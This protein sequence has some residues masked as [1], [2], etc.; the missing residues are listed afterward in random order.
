MKTNKD[1][2]KL[3]NNAEETLLLRD[4]ILKGLDIAKKLGN[5]KPFNIA[6][7]I[8]VEIENLFKLERRM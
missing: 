6:I 3:I 1:M 2:K 5:T 4:A 7:S 8:E